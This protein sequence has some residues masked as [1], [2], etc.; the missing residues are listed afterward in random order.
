VKLSDSF[1]RP[2]FRGKGP[3]EEAVGGQSSSGRVLPR[4]GGSGDDGQVDHISLRMAPADRWVNQ[5]KPWVHT[6]H[7]R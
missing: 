1:S 7:Y 3:P 2:G 4:T 6:L 5:T